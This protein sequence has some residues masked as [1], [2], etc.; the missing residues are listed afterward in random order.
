MVGKRICGPQI[1]CLVL[2]FALLG[3]GTAAARPSEDKV[4]QSFEREI[5]EKASAVDSIKSEL[6]KGRRHLA[7]LDQRA[8][9]YQ[10]RI[11]QLELNLALADAYLNGLADRIALLESDID[12][13]RHRTDSTAARLAERKQRLRQRVRSM[14]MTQ[15]RSFFEIL[16]QSGSLADALTKVRYFQELMA[17]DTLLVHTIDSTRQRL[18]RQ[19]DTLEGRRRELEAARRDK[20]DEQQTMSAEK[21]SH[22]IMLDRVRDEKKAYLAMMRELETAQKQIE[23]IIKQLEKKKAAALARAKPKEREAST[24]A[25]TGFARLKGKLPWPAKGTIV[26]EFGKI[27]HP[28]YQTVTMNPGVDIAIDAGTQVAAVSAGTVVY[29]GRMRG[30]GNLVVVDHG[31]DYLTIYA[32]LDEVTVSMDQ[33]VVEGGVVGQAAKDSDTGKPVVHFEVRQSTEA[34][35][36]REWLE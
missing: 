33:K 5:K 27:V 23:L 36:P 13:L 15:D 30:L 6:V 19:T 8:G 7:E 17:Y 18:E 31:G 34:L 20:E 4:V 12:S 16:L 21:E 1:S 11:G 9:D 10:E 35:D 26:R 3:C 25:A 14:Y 24:A 2:T 28:V 29:I 32:R 22:R